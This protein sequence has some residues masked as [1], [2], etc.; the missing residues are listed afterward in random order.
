MEEFSF[1]LLVGYAGKSEDLIMKKNIEVICRGVYSW[2]KIVS[3]GFYYK[4]GLYK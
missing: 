4:S 2:L 1:N 3:D